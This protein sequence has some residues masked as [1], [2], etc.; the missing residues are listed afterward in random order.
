MQLRTRGAVVCGDIGIINDISHNYIDYGK[1][2][3]GMDLSLGENRLILKEL[4]SALSYVKR[5]NKKI[6]YLGCITKY[7][8]F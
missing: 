8:K 3:S 6:K 7:K 1:I 4:E 5:Y 2:D